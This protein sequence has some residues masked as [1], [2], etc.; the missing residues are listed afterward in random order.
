[1]ARV[2]PFIAPIRSPY[3]GYGTAACHHEFGPRGNR[4]LV[5]AGQ[6]PR[7]RTFA[8]G[9]PHP[10]SAWRFLLSDHYRHCDQRPVFVVLSL[11]TGSG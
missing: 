6:P 11:S 1:M 2:T 8:E 3:H 5:A 7:A 10:Q 9:H 4:P